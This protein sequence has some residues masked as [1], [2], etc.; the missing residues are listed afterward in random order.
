MKELPIVDG[1]LVLRCVE[2]QDLKELYE[3]IYSDDVPEWK[4]WM[5]PITHLNTKVMKV[6]NKVCS[7]VWM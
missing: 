2:K 4:Q 5:H 7:N 6:L 3:L 1:E